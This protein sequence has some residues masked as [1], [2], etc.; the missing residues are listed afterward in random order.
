MKVNIPGSPLCLISQ[1]IAY[2][3]ALINHYANVQKEREKALEE[4]DEGIQQELQQR[5]LE[6]TVDYESF[7]EKL[8][9]SK[10]ARRTF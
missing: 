8:E 6:A 10:D 9:N 7:I 3:K 4:L 2:I 5:E 1:S